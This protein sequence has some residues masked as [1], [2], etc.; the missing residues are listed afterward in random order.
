MTEDEQPP[1]AIW[2]DSEALDAHFTQIRAKWKHT[3]GTGEELETVPLD[4][5]ELTRG[6]RGG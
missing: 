1:E 5:N 2:L 3:A 4:Q 6:L